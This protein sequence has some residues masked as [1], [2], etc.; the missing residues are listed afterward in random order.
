MSP[1]SQN[2]SFTSGHYS[3]IFNLSLFVVAETQYKTGTTILIS[4]TLPNID[5]VD[6]YEQLTSTDGCSITSKLTT[7][8]SVTIMENQ[9]PLQAES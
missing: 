6:G 5:F 7:I 9:V 8:V 3:F 1:Q 2:H 4:V